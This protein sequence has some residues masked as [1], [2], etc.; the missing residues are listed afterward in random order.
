MRQYEPIWNR[1][2]SLPKDEAKTKGVSITAP[3]QLHRR[4]IKAVIKEKDIDLG[5][6]LLLKENEDRTAKLV[7][8][9]RGGFV[10]FKLEF[11]I[12]LKD[13]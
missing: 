8:L 4:I 3:A 9:R 6:K 2:K 10:T 7:I 1:L 13:L 5:Y 12:G 11:S